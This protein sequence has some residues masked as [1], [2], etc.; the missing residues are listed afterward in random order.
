MAKK[1]T[2]LTSVLMDKKRADRCRLVRSVAV[3]VKQT[4]P[5]LPNV[6]VMRAIFRASNEGTTRERLTKDEVWTAVT[7]AAVAVAVNSGVA[8]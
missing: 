3:E 7:D 8:K 4:F 5:D 6:D 2:D 1:I